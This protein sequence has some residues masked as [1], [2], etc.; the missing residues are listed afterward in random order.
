MV[1][2]VISLEKSILR[3]KN[4]EV[5]SSIQRNDK[6]DL[7]CLFLLLPKTAILVFSFFALTSFWI[8]KKKIHAKG[9][10]RV[11]FI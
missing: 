8:S 4:H 10:L 9:N 3:E 2:S 7:W 5:I 1:L 11:L 6:D